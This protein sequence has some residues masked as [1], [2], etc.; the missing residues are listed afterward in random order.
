MSDSAERFKKPTPS[1]IARD[2]LDSKLALTGSVENAE[3]VVLTKD[4]TLKDYLADYMKHDVRLNQLDVE[5]V[6]P[7]MRGGQ[8]AKD[9]LK[10]LGEVRSWLEQREFIRSGEIAVDPEKSQKIEAYCKE[11]LDIC[12][13]LAKLAELLE[14]IAD[15]KPLN[16]D[17]VL[18]DKETL[19]GAMRAMREI[20]ED[21]EQQLLLHQSPEMF[22]FINDLTRA[23]DD[24]YDKGGVMP[25]VEELVDRGANMPK[26]PNQEE[27]FQMGHVE[28]QLQL[29]NEMALLDNVMEKTEQL[30][31]ALGMQRDSRGRY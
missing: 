13:E 28:G 3:G 9:Q 1:K 14:R 4:N 16:E 8:T 6:A 26:D 30:M 21:K 2:M 23:A 31:A 12:N 24:V 27:A 20:R 25:P 15:G 17:G 18:S 5:E 19:K 11:E 10:W 7:I 22:T 29:K